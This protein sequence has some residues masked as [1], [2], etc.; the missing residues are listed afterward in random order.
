MASNPWLWG[1]SPSIKCYQVPYL[2]G[3]SV[4]WAGNRGEISNISMSRSWVVRNLLV[5][6]K[7]H[8]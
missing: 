1:G 8:S 3:G 2:F 6:L 5:K 4:V 7:G